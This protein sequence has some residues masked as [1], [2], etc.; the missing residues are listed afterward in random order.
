MIIASVLR[1]KQN[2][3]NMQQRIIAGMSVCDLTCALVHL[4][5]P[6]W[7]PGNDKTPGLG[8]GTFC[9]VG[10]FI[11]ITVQFASILYNDILALYYLLIIKFNCSERRLKFLE[12]WFFHSFP[13]LWSFALS[14]SAAATHGINVWPGWSSACGIKY[15]D[16]TEYKIPYTASIFT[17]TSSLV[18]IVVCL[19]MIYI[20]VR[21]VEQKSKQWRLQR[22]HSRSN[23]V[24][25]TKLVA[26][27]CLLYFMVIFV[28]WIFMAIF[29]FFSVNN[30]YVE[31]IDFLKTLLVP[32]AG[33][34][35]GIVYFRLR[36]CKLR[37]QH[38]NASRN[39]II[40]GIISD[41]L[42]P[43]FC[44]SEAFPST[45]IDDDAMDLEPCLILGDD[46]D[47]ASE[48]S[49]TPS[50]LEANASSSTSSEFT[51]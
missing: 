50:Q 8:N 36:Y 9:T 11:L 13:I 41:K 2:R 15:D 39:Q 12:Q 22:D 43:C 27:Q 17:A 18:F 23:L 16:E 38:A 34:M 37:K 42:F 47:E 32:S 33:F 51:G 48:E 7:F 31:W 10:G 14:V 20:H 3:E 49:I 28:P 25:K 1:S 44:D 24:T 35:N 19:I 40:M 5:A 6:L 4:V 45:H 30:I 26:K 29:T 46:D 21:R